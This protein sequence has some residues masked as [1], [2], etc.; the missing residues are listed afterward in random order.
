[1]KVAFNARSLNSPLTGIGQYSRQLALGLA[2]RSDIEAKFFYGTH[3]SRQVRASPIAGA[4]QFLP[5]LRQ[6]VPFSYELRRLVESVQ[7]SRQADPTTIDLYHEPNIL[8]LPF[9][10]PTVITVHDLSWI[11]HAEAHPAKR[12]RALNK[13]FPPGLARATRVVTDSNF[14]RRE[15]MDVFSVP[16]ERISV[17]PLGVEPEFRPRTAEQTLGILR[18]LGLRHGQYLLVVGTMEPRKN[19]KVAFQ[20]YA[21][22]P[23]RIRQHI[24]LVLAGMK[25]WGDDALDRNLGALTRNDE[26]RFLGYLPRSELAFVIAGATSLVFPSIYEGFG[27]PPLEAMASGVPVIASI[28]AS[29]PEVVGEAGLL[30]D[31]HDIDGMT[32]AMEQFASSPEERHRIGL[33]GLERSRLFTWD[34]CV[35]ATVHAYHQALSMT[36]VAPSEIKAPIRAQ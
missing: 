7:F 22:L 14:V 23:A 4:S 32:Q 3:W 34:A 11:R 1:M 9:D 18:R 16:E 13:E 20:A 12:V 2:N 19:L 36:T 28:A 27:L 5:L 33:L 6:K 29:I 30:L 31:P 10:G 35:N 17:V 26:I 24:P 25:G 15:L 21:R 8:P